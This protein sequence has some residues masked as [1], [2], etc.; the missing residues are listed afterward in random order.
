MSDELLYIV[1]VCRVTPA[2]VGSADRRGR[3]KYAVQRLGSEDRL[4]TDGETW[5]KKNGAVL[6]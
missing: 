3:L 6:S 1:E 5:I 4:F 2:H